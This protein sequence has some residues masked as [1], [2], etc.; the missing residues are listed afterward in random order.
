MSGWMPATA[1]A[2]AIEAL[3][4]AMSRTGYTP[5]TTQDEFHV[6]VAADVIIR[7]LKTLGYALTPLVSVSPSPPHGAA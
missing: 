3:A 1:G 5:S 6:R 2:E 4:L 7:E